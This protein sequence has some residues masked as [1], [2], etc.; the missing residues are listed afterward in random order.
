[1][2]INSISRDFITKNGI[3][4]EGTGTVTSSTGQ[5]NSFQ[6]NGGAAIAKNLIVGTT[7]SIYGPLNV[8][9]Y[10][11]F[12]GLTATSTA[13]FINAIATTVAVNGTTATSSTA[14][15]AL[16]VIGGVGIGGALYV[17]GDTVLTGDIAING[18]DITTTQSIFNL[19]NTTATTVN[20]AGSSTAITIG[21]V[22]GSTTVRNDTTVTSTTT[23]VSTNT[24]AL[25]VRGGVGIGGN[26]YVG[27]TINGNLTGTVTTAT[28]LAGG[29]TGSIPYQTANGTTAFIP[30]GSN[31]Y[32]LTAGATTATWVAVSSLSAGNA[33]TATNIAGGATGSIPYQTTAGITGFYGPGTAGDLLISNGA[34]APSYNNTLTLAGITAASSTST[35]ALQVRGGAG[36]GGNL[37][38]GGN[39]IITGQLTINNTTAN[40]GTAASNS[41]YVSGGAWVEKTLV[42][43]QEALFKGSVTFT[44]SATY[45]LSTNTFYTDNILELHTPPNGVYG[46]WTLDDGK[47]IG[48]R[49]HYYTASA[50]TNAA[51]VLDNT[52]KELHWYGSGAES[53]T[54]DFSTAVFGMFRAGGIYAQNTE[55]ATS[56]NTGALRV[57]GGAGIG[58]DLYVGGKITIAGGSGGDINMAGGN[59][60]NVGRITANTGTFTSTNIISTSTA[61]SSST[62]ALTVAGGVGIG[63]NLYVG[64]S[65]YVGGAQVLTSA[66]VNQYA[67]QV[68]IFAGTDTAVN[69]STGAVTVWNTGT[70]QTVTGRGNTT[71]QTILITNTSTSNSTATGAL[72][73]VG[74]AGIGGALYVGGSISIGSVTTSSVITSVISNNYTQ[75]S[76]TSPTLTSITEV[77]LDTFASALYRTAKYL[78]QIVSS[79]N[80]HVE[81]ILL[82]HDG[83][84]VYIT[85]YGVSAS[86]SELGTFDADLTGG[87]VRLKF[88]PASTSATVVKLVRTGITS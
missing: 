30:I 24:G 16:I 77:I 60:T 33:T 53:P 11:T 9:G 71:N 86:G 44:G 12:A 3:L 38:V 52:T 8:I 26:L 50:D 27:G 5:V 88:T 36:I 79:A 18:G 2:P 40:T 22:S 82:Y 4:I 67:T 29:A 70:L 1:M 35:G 45:V 57:V 41:L 74:G 56:T 65:A 20:F 34:A 66:T 63:G 58:G 68:T 13:T 47:D 83:T 19:V 32:V 42:V 72:Q 43:G 14:T 78:V 28:S 84:S 6:S 10:S 31:G 48:L 62:G 76:Y 73:V 75:S 80:I 25:Q 85:E 17:G 51:L 87:N 69:T 61:S 49:F 39:E 54:G 46:Q 15:G 81:E 64:G 23:A 59:I 55:T 7:A 21:S 37:Y